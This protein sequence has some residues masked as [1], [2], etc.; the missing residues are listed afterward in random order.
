MSD[1]RR[2]SALIAL[3]QIFRATEINSRSLAKS[4]GLSTSQHIVLQVLA[5]DR[6]I[7]QRA[8]AQA[9]SLSQA[10]VTALLERMEARGLVQRER[11]AEDKR[12]VFV[13]I[14]VQGREILDGAP[15]LLQE[16]FSSRFGRLADWE[17]AFLVAALERTAKLLDAEEIDAAPVLDIGALGEPG[18]AR[19]RQS[20]E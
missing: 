20:H 3:R 5:D 10:T 18:G 19:E 1:H 15:G 17:Q 9:V 11:C 13:R 6:N 2:D 12:K 16:R 4:S 8:L 14:T 7:T